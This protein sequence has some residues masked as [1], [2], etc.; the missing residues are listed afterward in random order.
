MSIFQVLLCARFTSLFLFIDILKPLT[1]QFD[2]LEGKKLC[3]PPPKYRFTGILETR[4]MRV[5][6]SLYIYRY[7]YYNT[8]STERKYI[9]T[10]QWRTYIFYH[11][12]Y[13][14]K[15]NRIFTKIYNI[16]S[17]VLI[18]CSYSLTQSMYLL[19]FSVYFEVDKLSIIV[20]PS[21]PFQLSFIYAERIMKY[22]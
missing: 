13:S 8:L 3:P 1:K 21:P 11:F 2:I 19:N 18:D 15:Y 10:V 7:L 22:V 4:Y 9:I 17:R 5:T 6:P 20:P 16:N 12:F 14:S